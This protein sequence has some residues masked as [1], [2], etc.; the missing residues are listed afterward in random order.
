MFKI[1]FD[2]NGEFRKGNFKNY[3]FKTI[4]E[5]RKNPA[6]KKSF[7]FLA[8]ILEPYREFLFYIPSEQNSI[9]DIDVLATKEKVKNFFENDEEFQVISKVNVFSQDIT[10]SLSKYGIHGQNLV[11]L[12][13]ALSNFLLAPK[14]L[15]QVNSNM[16]IS[17]LAFIKFEEN[18]DVFEF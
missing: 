5:L 4:F 10:K 12:K 2:S 18:E 8:K 16:E 3:N 14:E 13:E 6:C 1:Y 7:E 17:N 11:G 15:I 9:I